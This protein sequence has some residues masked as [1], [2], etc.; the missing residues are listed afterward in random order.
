MQF[1]KYLNPLQK[2]HLLTNNK[3]N[4]LSQTDVSHVLKFKLQ[5]H[6]KPNIQKSQIGTTIENLANTPL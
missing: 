4:V 2:E 1:A 3:E 5:V 6:I